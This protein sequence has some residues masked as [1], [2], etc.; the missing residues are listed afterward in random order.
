MCEGI[1]IYE[2][3]ATGGDLRKKRIVFAT[4]G[5]HWWVILATLQLSLVT[6]FPDGLPASEVEDAYPSVLVDPNDP[7]SR[8]EVDA[9]LKKMFHDI[10]LPVDMVDIEKELQKNDEKL[11]TDT[12]KRRAA[13]QING[14]Q[15][16][17][18]KARKKPRG[19]TSRTK[20]TNAH[21]PGLFHLPVKQNA[22]RA[23]VILYP[24][25]TIQGMT[26]P[27]CI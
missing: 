23:V 10:K 1:A 13:E 19:I 6:S 5:W 3:N 17:P 16:G 27:A 22:T 21:L 11:A 8:M 4:Y 25:I 24:D 14:Q 20:L 18:E 9:E 12:A 26:M 2:L 15:R 7:R